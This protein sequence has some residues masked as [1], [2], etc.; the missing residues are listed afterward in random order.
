MAAAPAVGSVGGVA[1]AGIGWR[2]PHYAEVLRE[3]PAAGFLEVHSENFFADGGAALAVLQQARAHYPVSLHGVGLALGSAAGIDPWHL[4]QLA[5]LVERIEPMAVSDHAAFARAPLGGALFEFAAA[6]GGMA[7]AADLLPLPFN[8]EALDVLSANIQRVQDRL[9]RRL[10]VENLSAYLAPAGS[11][12]GETEFLRALAVRTGCGLIVDVNN[13]YVNALNAELA[14]D[15]ADPVAACKAWLDAVPAAF[16]GEL[17]VAGHC[18]TPELVIDDHGSRVD[19][20]VWT[21]YGHALERFGARVPT[22]VEWDT[23]IPAL[24]VLLG[25]ARRADAIAAAVAA[26]QPVLE[27]A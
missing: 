26:A 13:I 22:L 9:R 21:L 6:G 18:R 10:L 17:H 14:G 15:L 25:E 5:R 11:D 19:E 12:R 2:H 16:V 4:E 1:A 20:A 24:D 3:R 7:H 27:A 8:A 23:A